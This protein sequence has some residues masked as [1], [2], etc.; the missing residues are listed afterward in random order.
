MQ[1]FTLVLRVG[2]LRVILLIDHLLIETGRMVWLHRRTADLRHQQAAGGQCLVT[3]EFTLQAEPRAAREQAIIRIPLVCRG[4][5]LRAL[6]IGLAGDHESQHGLHVPPAGNELRGQPVDQFR[7][8]RRLTLRPKVL[9]RAHQSGAEQHLPETIHGHSRRQRIRRIDQPAC[10]T[11]TVA[12]K[13]VG[14]WRQGSGCGSRDL[15]A[16]LIILSAQQNEGVARLALVHHQRDRHLLLQFGQGFRE[17]RKPFLR[18]LLL[19]L[20]GCGL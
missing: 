17:F 5:E 10:Q 12:G 1:R 8:A 13:R 7:M 2:R 20:R 4:S 15:V 6:P 19:F 3:H 18:S 11:K 16:R 14:H 9:R